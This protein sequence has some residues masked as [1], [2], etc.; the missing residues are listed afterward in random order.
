VKSP[1]TT[2]HKKRTNNPEKESDDPSS[3]VKGLASI[4]KEASPFDWTG[5]RVPCQEDS[6]VNSRKLFFNV[7]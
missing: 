2:L 3:N 1:Q 5:T 6:G 7:E 4:E